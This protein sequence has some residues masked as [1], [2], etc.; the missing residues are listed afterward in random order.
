MD[1][2]CSVCFIDGL[3]ICQVHIITPVFSHASLDPMVAS[4]VAPRGKEGGAV[5]EM[6]LQH[7][8][9]ALQLFR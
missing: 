8:G 4:W 1:A 2:L 5:E 6:L 7:G 3:R 9:L